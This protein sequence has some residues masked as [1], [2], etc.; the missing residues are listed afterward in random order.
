M[1]LWRAGDVERPAHFQVLALVVQD[2]KL[3]GVEVDPRVDVAHEGVVGPRIP[4][5]GDDIE[6]LAGAGVALAMFHLL[7]HA[8]VQRGIG[9]GGRHQVPAGAAFGNVVERGEAPRDR[10]GRLEGRRRRRDQPEMAGVLGEHRQQS[11]RIERGHG[12]TA[13]QRLHGHVQHGQVIGHEEGVE[14]AALQRL[15]VADQRLEIEVGIGRTARIAPGGGMDAD[16]THEGA[17]LQL[18]FGGHAA[19]LATPEAAGKAA[20]GDKN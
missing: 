8:E 12:R 5:A 20:S 19:S 10:V 9:I 3:V 16:R 6:E 7:V 13:L 14:L 11:Q 18:A 2:V 1:A 4:Q 17:Q 15:G